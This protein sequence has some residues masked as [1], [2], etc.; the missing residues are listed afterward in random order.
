[1][2]A[3]Q[4]HAIA[5]PNV[6]NDV[7][8]LPIGIPANSP[9][10]SAP[11]FGA[12]RSVSRPLRS[13]RHVQHLRR[14]PD[15]LRH[16]SAA[17]AEETPTRRPSSDLLVYA[18]SRPW[19]AAPGC[20]AAP[21]CSRP[22]TTSATGWGVAGE[23]DAADAVQLPAAQ[24]YG[25]RH[26]PAGQGRAVVPAHRVSASAAR[27][28]SL[29]HLTF[30]VGSLNAGVA[31]YS[32]LIGGQRRDRALS[33]ARQPWPV[34]REDQPPSSSRCAPAW[35]RAR[36]AQAALRARGRGAPLKF[37]E[38]ELHAKPGWSRICAASPCCRCSSA[39]STAS[40]TKA[41]G[42]AARHGQGRGWSRSQYIG[43]KRVA[44][45]SSRATRQRRA[46]RSSAPSSACSRLARGARAFVYLL[47]SA[48][49]HV[50]AVHRLLTGHEPWAAST[51]LRA[52]AA[53][54][55]A[56]LAMMAAWG[57][58]AWADHRVE[59]LR[60]GD[61]IQGHAKWE[62]DC[63]SR[64]VKFDRA[65]QDRLCM[66][67][68]RP[69]ARQGRLP[70]PAEAAELPRLPPTTRARRASSNSTRSSARPQPD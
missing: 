65:A 37:A 8:R 50:I 63:K 22:A 13:D 44:R 69:D 58:S 17:Q 38:D 25:A 39:W 1:M 11:R 19:S 57:S 70:R 14:R 53:G 47:I 7:G 9:A 59:R 49:V 16:A 3:R 36:R 24:K 15:R 5:A 33:H 61:V 66:D 45:R 31:L 43:R 52:P 20:S 30:R 12:S 27:C 2:P 4:V 21:S 29:I 55:V 26:A 68:H 56:A 40:A 54:W 62:E 60:P 23:G 42:A 32:M 35:R 6:A 10:P 28:R 18:S 41:D 64:H 51:A 46:S 67:Y 34:G 48:I